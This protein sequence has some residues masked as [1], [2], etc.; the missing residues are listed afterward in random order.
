MK[1]TILFDIDFTLI[2]SA[3][4]R[5]IIWTKEAVLLGVDF[6]RLKELQSNYTKKLIKSTDFDPKAYVSYLSKTLNCKQKPLLDLYFHQPE[7]YQQASYLETQKTLRTLKQTSRLGIFTEGKRLAQL[8]K[9]K[10]AGLLAYFDPRLIFIYHR[11]LA[12]KVISSL[13]QG[14]LI[15]DDNR[16]VVETLLQYPRVTPIWLNRKDKT[17]HTNGTTIHTLSELLK[18]RADEMTRGRR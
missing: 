14:A 12:P 13:P 6:S 11:K 9:V 1:P 5:E 16:E 3:K 15:V 7:I 8:T 4:L 18:L 2:D 17:N 10:N